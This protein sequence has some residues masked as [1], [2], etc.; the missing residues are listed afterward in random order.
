M[1]ARDADAETESFRQAQPEATGPTPAVQ[2]PVPTRHE[3]DNGLTLLTVEKRD[4][5]L[6]HVRAVVRSGAAADPSD[7]PGLAA[8]TGAM[9]KAGTEQRTAPELADA[10]E[11]LGGDLSVSVD[12]DTTQLSMTVLRKNVDALLDLFHEVLTQPAFAEAEVERVRKR[13]LA[14]LAQQRDNPGRVASRAFLETLFPEHAYGH[15]PLGTREALQGIT[16]EDIVGFY[17]R[18]FHPQ[19]M[20]LVI[21]GALAD[22]EAQKRV[23]QGMGTWAK[24][25]ATNVAPKRTDLGEARLVLLPKDN[26]PQSQLRIGHV[27]IARDNKDYFAVLM[28]NAVLGG[29]FNSRINMNLREDKGFTYGAYSRFRAW[30]SPGPFVVATGVKTETT[31]PAIR[32]I[33]AEVRAMHEQG[34]KPEELEHAKRSYSLSLPGYFQTVAGI[35]AMMGNLY[36]YGLP[37]DYYDTLPE[38]LEGVSVDDANAAARE[39]LHPDNLTIVVVGDPER[40]RDDLEGLNYGSPDVQPL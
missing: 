26:A 3:L 28:C 27:G 17:E 23:S 8:F 15:T 31:A 40:I 12:Q 37:L 13:R 38:R 14:Q 36:A 21:V 39:Y 34:V 11:T 29:I 22:A 16:R 19:N 30:R 1:A 33:L 24:A 4:L 10:I 35:G 9:L 32:E 6:V 2:A 5:P 7:K 25:G 18:H 20:A